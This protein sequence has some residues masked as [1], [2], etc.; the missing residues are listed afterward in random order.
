M[1]NK[2]LFL[3]T[4]KQKKQLVFLGIAL[5]LGV[6][7]EMLGL[8]ILLP[9]IGILLDQDIFTK[10]P[11]LEHFFLFFGELT[12]TRV[13]VI[14][15][16]T[17]VIFYLLKA[18]FLSV[19]SWFQ[20]AFT[21]ELTADVANKLFYGYLSSPYDFHIKK[22]TAELL[23][24]V[25]NE[26]GQ[27]SWLTQSF[28]TLVVE[29]SIIFGVIFTL[30]IVEPI[31]SLS[32]ICFLSTAILIFHLITK[33]KLSFWGVI[34]QNNLT[35]M[36]QH[37]LQG[38]GGIKVVK[39]LGKE[40]YFLSKFSVHN[41]INKNIQTKISFIGQIPR[42]YLEFLC[43]FGLSALIIVMTF[44]EKTIDVLL[45][46]IGVFS[47]AAFR[48]LPSANRILSSINV[49]KYSTPIINLIYNEFSMFN[50]NDSLSIGDTNK[51]FKFDKNIELKNIKFAY[52]KDYVINDLTINIKKGNVIG[53]IGESGSGKST[54][55]DLILGLFKP[56]SGSIEVD[57]KNI[58]SNLESWQKNIGY[59]PQSIYL[60]DDTIKNNVA[61]GLN[62]NEID[63]KKVIKALKLSQIYNFI[64][65]LEDGINTTVGERGISFSG[66]QRQR[67]G[68]A[69][70]L[71]NDPS[72]LIFDEATSA[73]DVETEAEI[74]DTIFRFRENKTIIII[75]HRLTTVMN[76]DIIFKITKGQVE[77]F[78]TPDKLLN[79]KK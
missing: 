25:Q 26:V 48:M 6:L 53:L 11:F 52:K 27:F 38:L 41:E 69:R 8:G 45:P 70:A 72:L 59:V 57:G 55:V 66:G 54:L 61:F 7:L 1:I 28:I 13:V 32:V 33:S 44:Q 17:L 49:L 16:L 47:V 15:M 78:G 75:A 77:N 79:T 50:K 63:E 5:L 3:L 20:S 22:N 58:K 35:K 30:I 14:G 62:E 12:H 56:N 36:N 73:L 42:L 24:N 29:L 37:I 68:I 40:N 9:V 43:V 2:I 74:M 4:S 76:C 46:T 51:K 34:R 21:A 67:I 71:Y 23:R 10:F 65:S 19:L 18:L 39:Y 60:N 64:S 31:G